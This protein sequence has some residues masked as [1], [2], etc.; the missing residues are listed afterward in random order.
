MRILL[1]PHREAFFFGERERYL[2]GLAV[3][4]AFCALVGMVWVCDGIDLLNRAGRGI[5]AKS[6]LNDD[7]IVSVLRGYHRGLPFQQNHQ[8][9]DSPV[10]L[11]DRAHVTGTPSLLRFFGRK[12]DALAFPQ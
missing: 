2:L 6:A 11:I 10:H 7:V 3:I 9:L 4:L 12:I 5:L 1:V 8:L